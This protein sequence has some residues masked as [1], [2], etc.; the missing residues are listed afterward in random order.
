MLLHVVVQRQQT[1]LYMWF[2]SLLPVVWG[3]RPLQSMSGH[4]HYYYYCS[5]YFYPHSFI[6]YILYQLP[7]LNNSEHKGRNL[8][9]NPFM[10]PLSHRGQTASLLPDDSTAAQEARNYHQA[11]SQDEDISRHS[12]SA[13][14]QQTQ[15]VTLLHQC[16]DSYTQN[17]C[18]AHLEEKRR[19]GGG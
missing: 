17:S 5:Y 19:R 8:S 7:H 15:V 12:K 4:F 13:G 10:G 18:S 6:A 9:R 2:S 1:F 16:P 11:A 14:C 3:W